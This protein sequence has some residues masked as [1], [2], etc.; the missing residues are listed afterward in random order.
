MSEEYVSRRN[1]MVFSGLVILVHLTGMSISPGSASNSFVNIAF[2]S[3]Q[4]LV[5]LVYILLFWYAFRYWQYHKLRLRKRI[6][7]EVIQDDANS[8]WWKLYVRKRTGKPASKIDGGVYIADIELIEN[9]LGIFYGNYKRMQGSTELINMFT[10]SKDYFIPVK[11]VIGWF[12]ITLSTLKR[13]ILQP[14]L[15]SFFVPYLLFIA[16]IV[17]MF[18]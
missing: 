12:C 15:M 10:R 18:L 8:F 11:G 13:S 9:K 3:E 7:D 16:A 4:I 1:L 6:L 17:S 2:A 5:Y 14:T